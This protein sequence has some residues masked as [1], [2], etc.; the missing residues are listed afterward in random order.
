MSAENII[1]VVPYLFAQPNIPTNWI[2]RAAYQVNQKSS[3]PFDLRPMKKTAPKKRAG[4][5]LLKK[6]LTQD[7]EFYLPTIEDYLSVHHNDTSDQLTFSLPLPNL[8]P[9][10]KTNQELLVENEPPQYKEIPFKNDLLTKLKL[11]LC[12]KG[13]LKKTAQDLIYL[14]PPQKLLQILTQFF[15]NINPLIPVILPSEDLERSKNIEELGQNFFFVPKNIYCTQN[16]NT[17]TWHLTFESYD[18]EALRQ[19]Y[20]LMSKPKANPFHTILTTHTQEK[21]P[22]IQ[23]AP[24]VLRINPAC[25][26]A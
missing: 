1:N 6:L 4:R 14:E 7:D 16:T 3:Y 8:F 15:P 10:V 25:C 24:T 2:E 21:S 12:M 18:L 13:T 5:R 22:P 17:I 19:K 26:P 11:L 20:H 23:E 9:D